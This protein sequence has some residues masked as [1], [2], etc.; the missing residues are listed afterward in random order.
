[1]TEIKR[2]RMRRRGNSKKDRETERGREQKKRKMR[3]WEAKRTMRNKEVSREE[4]ENEG[5]Q[6]RERE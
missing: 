2:S 4:E 3:W 5:F 1:V 6:G